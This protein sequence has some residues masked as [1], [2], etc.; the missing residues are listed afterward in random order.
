MY[1]YEN[2]SLSSPELL[3]MKASSSWQT[4]ALFM[5]KHLQVED[6]GYSFSPRRPSSSLTSNMNAEV[7]K[8]DFIRDENIQSCD[9][10]FFQ[11]LRYLHFFLIFLIF[12]NECDWSVLS[13]VMDSFL[14]SKTRSV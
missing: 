4:R 13:P 5:T 10:P 3:C 12:V 6:S 7:N 8:Y 11:L 9:L 14:K 2:L 1:I